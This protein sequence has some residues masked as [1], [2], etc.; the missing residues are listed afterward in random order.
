M[1][2]PKHFISVST[3]TLNGKLAIINTSAGTS[4]LNENGINFD[5]AIEFL[6]NLVY[7]RNEAETLVFVTYNFQRDCEFIFATMP[8]QLKDKLFKSDP[9]QKK[10]TEIELENNDLD[11]IIY[12]KRPESAEY[13]QADFSK[14][15]NNFVMKDLL[16][17]EHNGYE[18]EYAGG[19]SL[20]IRHAGKVITFYDIAGF[21]K[22]Q[23]L[24]T[25]IKQWFGKDLVLLDEKEL[26]RVQCITLLEKLKIHVTLKSSAVQR[27][28]QKLNTELESQSLRL[29]RYH[30]AS[31]LSSRLLGQL[32]AK[33]EFYNYRFPRQLSYELNKAVWQANYGGRAEQFKIGTL[34]NV[35]VY[36]INSA[37]AF[38]CSY[39]PRMLR[40]PYFV[41]TWND[42]PFSLWF[43]DYDFNSVN[44]Y[45]GFLPNRDLSNS[46]KYKMKG[47]G[48]FWQ[49]EIQFVLKHY[50]EC[51]KIQGG[52]VLDYERADFA[53]G[54]ET[55]Y[56]L[57]LELQRQHNP[58]ERVLKLALASFYGK[59]C[60]HVGRSHYYNLFY[61]GFV[62]SFTRM[63]LLEATKGREA[64]TICFQTDA[65]H[66]TSKSLGVML[67]DEMGHYKQ[68]KYAKVEY[69]GTGTWRG[70][71]K[72]GAVIE[73]KTQGFRSFDFEKAI[74]Q[75][76]DKQTYDALFEFF[77]THNLHA[78]NMFSG[79]E[80]LSNHS[81][82]KIQNPVRSDSAMRLFEV[83]DI[84]LTKEYFNSK[85]LKTFSGL[86]SGVYRQN[87]Y[88]GMIET[89]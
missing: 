27:L 87:N 76:N 1:Q 25:A 52:F 72:A 80:Y 14:T 86:E 51:V 53:K 9:V 40:K 5:T 32:G 24:R 30:G 15:V 57:R 35:Y 39:L 55:L 23:T 60:Q 38:A 36:D 37:Y 79:A 75:M 73:E 21:F 45:F 46:T 64:E 20:I 58:L 65:I 77:V 62:T 34:K 26:E 61:A 70:F 3:E 47:R 7:K 2:K 18:V 74:Q 31:A 48:Y 88:R 59:F 10:L 50:P 54:I 13:A 33:K 71:N 78:Q 89:I 16:T 83:L 68:Q 69:L 67:N 8:R 19:K 11:T 56:Q 84:D 17:V 6:F 63:Q 81:M 28:A 66:S 42:S 82:S 44:P 22:G 49:P 4:L 41:K 43:C 12:G 29:T 85:P